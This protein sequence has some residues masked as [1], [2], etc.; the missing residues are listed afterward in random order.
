MKILASVA[1]I[2]LFFTSCSKIVQAPPPTVPVKFTATIYQTLAPFNNSGTPTNLENPDAISNDLLTYVKN[3][4][5]NGV[6]LNNTHPELLSNGAIADIAITKKTELH[7]TFVSGVTGASDA[8]GIYTYPTNHPPATAT[9]IQK[10]T[11][12]FANA[13]NGTT[14]TA[15]DKVNIG[16]FEAG[17]SIGFVL[18]Q[19]GWN[20]LTKSVDYN[21]VHFCSNDILNPETSPNLKK[22]AVL[23]NY[24]VESKLLIGFEDL[25]RTDKAADSDF[26]DVV[27]YMT[28]FAK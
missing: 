19:N 17:T 21:V 9:D 16:V 4:L 13:G 18:L 10:I 22:H 12:I 5:P 23:I 28:L 2:I 20:S 27:F 1:S 3:T 7:M 6:N 26:N 25:D 11:I 8:I 15:G 24:P 14:L